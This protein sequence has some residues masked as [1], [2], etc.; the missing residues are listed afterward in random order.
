MSEEAT[1]YGEATVLVS[2]APMCSV[3]IESR[4]KGAPKIAV[5]VYAQTAAEAAWVAREQYDALMALYAE[6]EPVP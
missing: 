3:E 4:A 1:P 6:S 5:K 2:P